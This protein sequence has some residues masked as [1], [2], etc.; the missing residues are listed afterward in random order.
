MLQ[1]PPVGGRLLMTKRRCWVSM[2]RPG[3]PATTGCGKF[4]VALA[5]MLAAR[6]DRVCPSPCIS[7]HV[8]LLFSMRRAGTSTVWSYRRAAGICAWNSRSGP[9]TLKCPDAAPSA[10]VTA[11]GRCAAPHV[12]RTATIRLNAR[13]NPRFQRPFALRRSLPSTRPARRAAHHS[14][15]AAPPSLRRSLRLVPGCR[16]GLGPGRARR[17]GIPDP[18]H[19]RRHPRG[20]RHARRAGLSHRPLGSRPAHGRRGQGTQVARRHPLRRLL[21]RSLRRPHAGHHRHVRFPALPQRR[22]L[23]LPAPHPLPAHAPR[24]NR[25]GHLRQGASRHD[26]GARRHPRPARHPAAR[27]RHA[28]A[29]RGR[30]CGR[31]A[32]RRRALRPR[33]NDPGGR[34]R[35]LCG[36]C[37]TPGGGCQFLGTAATSQVVGE[38]LG[39]SLPHSALAPS[40]HPIWTDMARR[41]ARAVLALEARGLDHARHPHR[42]ARCAT[43]WWCTPRS[44]APPT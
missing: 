23:G 39:M 2:R 36:A 44:A 27:R 33:T 40:G 18:Q 41:S 12:P 14:R 29:R 4:S 42:G 21:H 37:A 25:R 1:S 7:R 20:R 28:A 8:T 32:I 17:Q 22:R 10:S 5:G 3:G 9:A 15:D 11:T 16:H 34:A 26:D 24:R 43:P 35:N 6:P 31:R 19:P 30:G 38:A 13:P